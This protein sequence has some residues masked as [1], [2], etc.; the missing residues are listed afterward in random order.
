MGGGS[1]GRR[2]EGEVGEG[3]TKQDRSA[4]G[5]GEGGRR[6]GRGAVCR[7]DGNWEWHTKSGTLHDHLAEGGGVFRGI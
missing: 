5:W 1:R 2:G 4:D 3:G 7:P 6:E